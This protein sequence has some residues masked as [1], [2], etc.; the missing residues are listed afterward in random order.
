MWEETDVAF[1]IR[2]GVHNTNMLYFLKL[3]F[4]SSCFGSY[5]LFQH[6]ASLIMRW[7]HWHIRKFSPGGCFAP[8]YSTTHLLFSVHIIITIIIIQPSIGPSNPCLVTKSLCIDLNKC[9]IAVQTTL[10]V[11]HFHMTSYNERK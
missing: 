5:T 3:L 1:A 2:K 8:C 10:Y 6:S 9:R 11:L 4:I 7:T